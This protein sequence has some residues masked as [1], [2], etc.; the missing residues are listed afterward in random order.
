MALAKAY[1]ENPCTLVLGSVNTFYFLRR[2]AISKTNKTKTTTTVTKIMPV[3]THP[4]IL[5]LGVSIVIVVTFDGVLTTNVVVAV[6]GVLVVIFG[7]YM[8][9]YVV[10]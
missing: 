3:I 4:L 5:F 1:P 8:T 2:T 10:K 7:I 9:L 6:V